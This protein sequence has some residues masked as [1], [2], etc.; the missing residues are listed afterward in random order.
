MWSRHYMRKYRLLE[1]ISSPTVAKLC[2]NENVDM[3][4][5]NKI[6]EF[7]HCQPSDIMEY[8]PDNNISVHKD[9]RMY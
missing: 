8:K 9:I 2:K 6:C 5:I 4:T 3:S 7:L 1:V